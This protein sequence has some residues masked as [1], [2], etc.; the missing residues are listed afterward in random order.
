MPIDHSG[1]ALLRRERRRR[2]LALDHRRLRRRRTAPL[3]FG[4]G[5]RGGGSEAFHHR[6]FVAAGARRLRAGHR[7][8]RPRLRSIT[9]ASSLPIFVPVGPVRGGGIDVSACVGWPVIVCCVACWPPLNVRRAGGELRQIGQRLRAGERDHPLA[10]TV[11]LVGRDRVADRFERVREIGRPWRSALSRLFS[12][13][14]MI[15]D[16]SCGGTFTAGIRARGSAAASP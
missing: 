11:F 16:S 12:S 7:S 2:D 10:E 4:G 13:D 9:V 3:L 8:R 14:F 1:V 5:R 6:R 15:T